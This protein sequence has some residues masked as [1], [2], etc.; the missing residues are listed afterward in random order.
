MTSTQLLKQKLIPDSFNKEI[1]EAVNLITYNQKNVVYAGSFIRRSI[2]DA[3]DID[4]SETF[5]SVADVVKGFQSII[6]KLKENNIV[7]ILDIKCGADPNICELF[8]EL[9]TIKNGQI[10]NFNKQSV[11]DDIGM[12]YHQGYIDKK[13]YD[14]LYDLCMSRSISDY[15]DLREAIRKMMTLRWTPD[16]I[17]SGKKKLKHGYIS[18]HD[19]VV[20]FINKIDIVFI[21]Q[22]FYTEMS[23]ILM[24]ENNPNHH[25]LEFLPLTTNVDH[26]LTALKFNL[27]EYLHHKEKNYL[28]AIK[29]M[30]SI[31]VLLDDKSMVQKIFP[32]LQSNIAILNRVNGILKT[33]RDML[34]KYSA[35]ELMLT[36]LDNL[37]PILAYIFEFDFAERQ[38]DD[39]IDHIKKT[40]IKEKIDILIDRFNKVINRETLKYINAN[41]IFI[42]KK[43][44]I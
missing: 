11:I 38:V 2:R 16:D 15:L 25:V 24:L 43:Y 30:F 41:H 9:G 10:V 26:F 1:K 7:V 4:M 27:F 36:M 19:A 12:V 21:Y 29:R 14:E 5:K 22:G 33:I 35:N 23:N 20:M 31:A 13:E 32:L 18:L 40:N 42:T 6:K 8:K 44:Q 37:K 39:I 34:D 3:S 17:L 28:K